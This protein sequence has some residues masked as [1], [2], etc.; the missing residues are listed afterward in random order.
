MPGSSPGGRSY[1]PG[2]R[3][4]MTRAIPV[5]PPTARMPFS[6]R[7]LESGGHLAQNRRF[8]M[9]RSFWSLIA[10]QV[11]VLLNDNAAKLMLMTLGLAVAPELFPQSA[12]TNA[13]MIKT[14][15]AA[16]ILL[17]FLIFSPTAGWIS[18]R[19]SKRDVILL[20]LW[21]QFGVMALIGTALLA[22]NLWFSI[23]GLFL[24]GC[25]CAI[26]SPAKQGII[27]EIVTAT[28]I[29]TA[30]G[31]VEVS[32]IASMLVGGL[33]GGTLFDF[34]MNTLNKNPWHAAQATMAVLTVLALL[35]LIAGY[36]IQKTPAHTNQP[37][38]TALLWEHFGQLTDVWREPPIRLC[39]L[40]ISYFYGLAGALYLTLFEIS[41][42]IHA[43]GIG[44]G[45]NTGVYAATLGLGIILGSFLV[46]RLTTHQVELGLIPIGSL[47]LIGG[48]VLAGNAN[49]QGPLFLLA[50]FGM[51]LAGAMFVVPL[52]AHL[53]E[54]VEP[55]RR[56]RILSANNLFVN[57]FGI[58]AVLI[59]YVITAELGVSPRDQLFLYTIPTAFVTAYMVFVTPDGLLRLALGLLGRTFYRV[60]PIGLENLPATGGVLLLPN[61][62][63]YVDAVILQLACPRPIRFLV[64]DQLY[65]QGFLR[66]GLKLLGTIPISPKKARA[67][68]ETTVDALAHGEVV[69]L[70]PEGA[71]T[72]TATLQ[73]LNRGYE[74]IARKARVP[75]MPVWLENV[76]GSVFSYYG[77]HFFWKLPRVL[78]LRVSLS[79]G[80]PLTGE[81]ATAETV[82]RR[83]Y[84]LSAD[85]FQARPELRSH[86]G[87]E[88]LRS[89]RR[90]FFKP[91]ITDAYANDRT[92]KGGELLAV[93]LA[94]AT[95]LKKN[96]PER[97]VGIVLP[98]GLGA[99]VANLGVVL[100][101][102]IPVNLNFTA[103]RAA[104]ESAIARAGLERII[105][106]AA[107]ADQ[108][109]DFPWPKE[110]ID[111][112]VLLKSFPK[113]QLK[114]WGF[115][116][117][118][119]PV[120]LL[121]RWLDLP[122]WGDGEE[123]ALLFTSG[124]AG[125]PKG[126]VLSHR[127][128][129]SN[130]AQFAAVLAQ[131]DLAALLGSLPVF[132]SFGFTVTL[133]W[134]I[135]GGPRVVT[136]PSPLDAAK[137][138][139]T[140]ERHKLELLLTTPTFLR[141]F[142]RK[143]KPEQLRSLK[144]VVT[145]AE[146]LPPDLLRD[147]EERFGIRVCE[148]YG[149]TEASPGVAVNLPDLPPS[150]MNP[151]GVLGRRIGSVGRMLP[152]LAARI[153]DPETNQDLSLFDSG[154][155]WLR[156]ANVFS[157]YLSDPKR[158]DEVLQDGWY[159]TGDVGRLDE[160]GFLFIEGRMSRF[161][162]IA[163]EMVPHLTIE[164]KIME[165]LDRPADPHDGPVITVVGVADEKRG[166][167]LVALTTIEIDTGE[168]RKRL[169]AAGLPNL[170]VPKIFRRVQAI[171]LLATGKL[172]L[173][174]CEKLAREEEGA[175]APR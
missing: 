170:W 34:C 147:F 166:E 49:P 55:Q 16:L 138:V 95:W 96:V 71:L 17:P 91:V 39:I 65:Q 128:I 160:D 94:F 92:L 60:M 137:L 122:R 86:I 169:V 58:V 129:L 3:A 87:Y 150:R 33:A 119:T 19:F 42:S 44:T 10:V 64:Y 124:S 76:W 125:E 9:K 109:K 107:M 113:G 72:R 120:D 130:T 51:G 59:Q 85:A 167:S 146:K 45:S 164:Q 144:L 73:K 27:K 140:I 165:A 155:L 74:L 2:A 26:F 63:S 62:I 175:A 115:L 131:I 41:A 153:R 13:K 20:S 99:T 111:L 8:H 102:K 56:G 110:R 21:A 24:L 12:E 156:G 134:P 50:L 93:G 114:R 117:L 83:L 154:M 159:K 133:W 108:L 43:N 67:A 174:A 15:L 135:L 35:S 30:V 66:W 5:F 82:R 142:L 61:H 132:H 148:G 106:A 116:A 168:L 171:P 22:H 80:A 89:L 40:G 126:V 162:K 151:D 149:M 173:R 97:R 54:Q 163:G 38:R 127:N 25:Q 136:Y 7:S 118:V 47:G 46:T 68:I 152:G 105:T 88:S 104:N 98:P 29:S 1:Q 157:G 28:K 4:S 172:D 161:S 79:F 112:A 57:L 123:A 103:G 70:F 141:A 69:C 100:A 145:G 75:V 23:L 158:T 84:D 121:R 81:E 36:Q 11:Q 32:A 6:I 53:Q 37:F 78:P 18:D 139:E 48:A 14:L 52:T 143:A 31:V 90:R 77:G 101:G